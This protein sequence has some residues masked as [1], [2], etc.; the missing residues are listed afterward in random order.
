MET[1]LV[2]FANEGTSFVGILLDDFPSFAKP[3]AA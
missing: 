3:Q 1:P 2:G